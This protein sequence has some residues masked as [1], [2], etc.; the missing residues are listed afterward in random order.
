MKK[1]GEGNHPRFSDEAEFGQ[2]RI[3]SLIFPDIRESGYQKRGGI[4]GV[5]GRGLWK[6]VKQTRKQ[7][8]GSGLR[9]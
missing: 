5:E 6:S 7:L 2:R 1:S 9:E 3:P 4:A 8:L